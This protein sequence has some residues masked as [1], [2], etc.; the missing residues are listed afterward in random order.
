[1]Y[2]RSIRSQHASSAR[3][4]LESGMK[5][6]DYPLFGQRTMKALEGKLTVMVGGD[7]GCRGEANPRRPVPKP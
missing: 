4:P 7:P 3:M 6:L 2:R 1:M 5:W